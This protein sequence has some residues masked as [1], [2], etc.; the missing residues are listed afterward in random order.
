MEQKG[1]WRQ[2]SSIPNIIL[3]KW[4]NEEIDRGHKG[5]RLYSKEF[6]EIIQ[7]IARP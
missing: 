4:L 2:T 3:M 7:E 6:D 5:L 1:E